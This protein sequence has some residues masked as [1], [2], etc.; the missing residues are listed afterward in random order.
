MK[1]LT[2]ILACALL[3][4]AMPTSAGIGFGQSVQGGIRGAVLDPGGAV[5]P[6]VEVT[7]TNEGTN[8]ARS[9]TTNETGQFVFSAVTPGPYKLSAALPG[10][11]TYN[12]AGLNIGAAQFITIK[13]LSA[14]RAWNHVSERQIGIADK[15]MLD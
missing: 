8:V 2:I 5:I 4:V 9:T 10:F 13:V 7:L 6:G 1:R 3:F 11:K 12:R 15:T 14:V